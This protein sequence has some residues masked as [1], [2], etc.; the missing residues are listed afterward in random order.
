MPIGN[1]NIEYESPGLGAANTDMRDYKLG[2]APG[3]AQMLRICGAAGSTTAGP[4][5]F[6]YNHTLEGPFSAVRFKYSNLGAA[7][8][9]LNLAKCAG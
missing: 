9:T 1:P 3:C 6:T 4:F 2:T 8:Y 5:T 7:T